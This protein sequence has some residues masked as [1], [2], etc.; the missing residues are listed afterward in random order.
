M[1]V[2]EGEHSTVCRDQ[3][4]A[5]AVG[6]GSD[7]DDWCV[8]V[9]AA[10]RAVEGRPEGEDAAVG[11]TQPVTAVGRRSDSDHWCVQRMSTHEPWKGVPN[12]KTPPSEAPTGNPGQAR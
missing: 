8:E 12:V 2:T 7:A 10:H 3:V 4:V 1:S 9:D 11:G 5:T 6:R